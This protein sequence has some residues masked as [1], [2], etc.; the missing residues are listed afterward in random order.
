MGTND[1]TKS[2]FDYA[3]EM[4]NFE[5]NQLVQRNN[6]FMVF[7]GVLLYGVVSSQHTIPIVSLLT[8]FAGL[9]VSVCQIGMASGAKFWQEYWEEKMHSSLSPCVFQEPSKEESKRVVRNRLDRQKARCCIIGCLK[10]PVNFLISMRFSVSRIP[11]Y[12]GILFSFVWLLLLTNTIHVTWGFFSI[13][14]WIDGFPS[15][16]M[17]SGQ[18]CGS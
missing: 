3:L 6:F 7:Q 15:K 16:A 14:I 18:K 1:G 10:A 2:N 8:C 17:N 4:R 11:I 13:P 9:A 5:I 12:A